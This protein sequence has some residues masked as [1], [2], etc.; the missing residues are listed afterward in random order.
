VVVESEDGDRDSVVDN[1]CDVVDVDDLSGDAVEDDDDV[2]NVVAD[3][4]VE[5]GDNVCDG[6]DD[7]VVELIGTNVV[8]GGGGAH[9]LGLWQSHGAEQ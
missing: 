6:V 1:D 5:E 2:V 8:V 9:L 4:V 7:D 3:D